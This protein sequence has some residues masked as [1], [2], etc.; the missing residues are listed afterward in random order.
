MARPG[1]EGMGLVDFLFANSN[2]WLVSFTHIRRGEAQRG[3]RDGQ[4]QIAEPFLS[5]VRTK[6]ENS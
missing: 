2:L 1:R 5:Y 3:R 4:M 6:H